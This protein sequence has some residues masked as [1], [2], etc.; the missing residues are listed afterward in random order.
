LFGLACAS[1]ASTTTESQT[2]LD[3][4]VAARVGSQ[5]ISVHAVSAVASAQHLGPAQARSRLIRDALFAEEARARAL[6]RT[7]AV[8]AQSR[9]VLASALSLAIRREAAQSS[10]SPEELASFTQMHWLDFDRPVAIRTVHAVVRVAEN[11]DDAARKKAF[12]LAARI[13]DAVRNTS[14]PQDFISAAKAVPADGLEV[15]AEI[16]P[17]VTLD[18]RTADLKNR[19]PPNAPD[20]RFDKDFSA[21]THRLKAVGDTSPPEKSVFGWHIIRALEIQPAQHLPEKRRVELLHDEIIASRARSKLD[22]L[23]EEQ[24]KRLAP[25]IERNAENNL[26]TL[27][28]SSKEP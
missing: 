27:Q 15:V 4:S 1:P 19:P 2:R 28:L 16:L 11:A 3:N 26:S 12:D 7:P 25:S 24:R 5:T 17:P 22:T 6:H 13:A 18:G 8:Q 21:A 9:G 20:Q 14:T 10:I 23:I